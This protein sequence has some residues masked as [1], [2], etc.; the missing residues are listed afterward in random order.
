MAISRVGSPVPHIFF[1][2]ETSCSDQ[3]RVSGGRTMAAR[4]YLSASTS[5]VIIVG[6]GD[7]NFIYERSWAFANRSAS[8]RL[9]VL[10][11]LHF[12]HCDQ[13]ARH[14]AVEDWQEAVDLLL[15]VD[16]LHHDRQ[17]LR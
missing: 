14:H 17:V 16:D 11:D 12:F 4:R 2:V 1:K 8:A 15:R 3:G 7:C 10:Q 13:P 5:R 6:S 9:P